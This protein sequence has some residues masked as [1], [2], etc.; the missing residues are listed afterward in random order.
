MELNVREIK[1]DQGIDNSSNDDDIYDLYAVSN[2]FGG[3]G[4]GH[5]NFLFML[6]TAYAKNPIDFKW[7]DCDDSRISRHSG[8]II[9]PATYLLFYQKR[10]AAKIELKL[11]LAKVKVEQELEIERLERLEQQRILEDDQRRKMYYASS[12][13][14][15]YVYKPS[16]ISSQAVSHP[17]VNA[18]TG[19]ISAYDSTDGSNETLKSID[20]LDTPQT[21]LNSINGS[22]N[23]PVPEKVVRT[24]EYTTISPDE[25]EIA[26][27][28]NTIENDSNF[29]YKHAIHSTAFRSSSDLHKVIESD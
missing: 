4:G 21:V 28:C 27:T 11:I 7:Y 29:S 5:C 10:N 8:D 26:P 22:L 19:L 17:S 2:H 12:Q 24:M 18:L 14:N 25:A 16:S 20:Q 15:M 9:T 3:L 6:D 23:I 13:A 1:I